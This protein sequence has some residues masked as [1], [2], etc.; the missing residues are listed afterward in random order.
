ML[1]S[2]LEGG[3]AVTPQ[4]CKG[5]LTTGFQ[6]DLVTCSPQAQIVYYIPL[7]GTQLSDWRGTFK[8]ERRQRM[9]SEVRP[10]EGT[11]GSAKDI[12]RLSRKS[13]GHDPKSQGQPLLGP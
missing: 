3:M 2:G 10:G 1:T 6:Q 4:G 8:G 11:V 12:E 13:T 7:E 5:K 9:K